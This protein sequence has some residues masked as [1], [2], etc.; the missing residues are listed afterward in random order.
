MRKLAT[1]A[2]IG[3]LLI[4]L[5][6]ILPKIGVFRMVVNKLQG[7][8]TVEDR[9]EQYGPAARSRLTRY[10]RAHKLKYPPKRVI[11]LVLKKEKL[12]QLYANTTK[13]RFVHIKDFPVAAASGELG[14]K[15]KEGDCQVPEGV[16]KIVFLNPNSLYHLSMRLDYPNAF[17]RKMAK[18][19]GRTNLGGDIMIHGDCV[20]I[21]CVA[22][23][24][25]ISEDL[26]VMAADIGIENVKV[27]V[28]PYDFRK[29]PGFV[30]PANVPKW[31]GKLYEKLSDEMRALSQ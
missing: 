10:F 19:D 5:A 1:I 15:L 28:A 17:D 14:P 3:I 6:L 16:Y 12:L 22:M 13:G 11:F 7:E 18:A 29:K 4:I 31:T 9:L 21:G 25:E 26:F 30:L 24:N 27:V 20:S 2:G 23:G 8:K